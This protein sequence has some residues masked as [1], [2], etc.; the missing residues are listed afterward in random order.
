MLLAINSGVPITGGNDLVMGTP[1][2]QQKEL[3]M[4]MMR[5]KRAPARSS[6]G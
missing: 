4:P 3:M 5:L 2:F 1:Q 6:A